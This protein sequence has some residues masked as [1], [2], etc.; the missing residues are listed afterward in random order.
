MRTA[1]VLGFVANLILLG[2]SVAMSPARIAVHF[3]SGGVPD[4]WASSSVHATIMAGVHVLVFVVFLFST[5]VTRIFPKRFISIPNRD[6]WLRNENWDKAETIL[7]QEM[8]VF[9]FATFVFMFIVSLLALQ[10]NLSTPV[11]LREDLFWWPFGLFMAFTTYWTIR[12][13]TRFRIPE[14][15][16][17]RQVARPHP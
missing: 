4:S 1:F 6:Y 10:A 3:G 14:Q 13:V 12:L 7:S 15:E 5:K 16:F 11:E 17:P 2:V 8:Y 9:G